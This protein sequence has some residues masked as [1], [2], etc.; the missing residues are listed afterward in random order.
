MAWSRADAYP[1]KVRGRK[2]LL[3]TTK[4][5]GLL[6]Y[7]ISGKKAL[8]SKSTEDYLYAIVDG[9]FPPSN[10]ATMNK[11]HQPKHPNAVMRAL[12][13]LKAKKEMEPQLLPDFGSALAADGME[14]DQYVMLPQISISS[15]IAM[16]YPNDIIYTSDA[17]IGMNGTAFMASIDLLPDHITYI[18]KA[19]RMLDE[20]ESARNLGGILLL[21]ETQ[22]TFDKT[23]IVLILTIGL[24]NV[25][26]S[27]IG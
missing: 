27:D 15:V 19:L 3:S 20:E 2:Y 16:H 23:P 12:H 6:P 21:R 14:Q 25:E 17:I 8:D 9:L 11:K 13:A 24:G 5:C 22:I 7:S 18:T 10:N 4:A 26:E 1:S